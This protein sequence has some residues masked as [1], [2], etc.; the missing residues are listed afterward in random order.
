MGRLDLSKKGCHVCGRR[1]ARNR[2]TEREW[3]T[4]P[5]CSVHKVRFSIPYIVPIETPGR[6]ITDARVVVQ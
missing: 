6:V 1:L 2:V 3:C 4:H 5:P